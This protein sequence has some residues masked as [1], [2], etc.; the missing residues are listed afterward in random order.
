LKSCANTVKLCFDGFIV[1]ILSFLSRNQGYSEPV[2]LIKS[3]PPCGTVLNQVQHD[4]VQVRYREL[5]SGR[6]SGDAAASAQENEPKHINLPWPL[7]GKEGRTSLTASLAPKICLTFL[8]NFDL[9]QG[10]C[11]GAAVT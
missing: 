5:L 4:V 7:L 6:R 11:S 3:T 9:G 10:M 2:I 1:Y 8:T